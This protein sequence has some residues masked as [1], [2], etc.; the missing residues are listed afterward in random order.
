MSQGFSVLRLPQRWGPHCQAGRQNSSCQAA[1]H[2]LLSWTTPD[3]HAGS[4]EADAD[5]EP[6]CEDV[7]GSTL[8]KEGE[9]QDWAESRHRTAVQA[10]GSRDQPE[11]A[12]EGG[13]PVRVVPHGS[14]WQGF[15]P[16][17]TQSLDLDPGC[18][19]KGV[20]SGSLK[21]RLTQTELAAGSFGD[22]TPHIR[23]AGSALKGDEAVPLCVTMAQFTI[24][25]FNK[26]WLLGTV[27][28]SADTGGVETS[29]SLSLSLSLS[30][31][32][33]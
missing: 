18:P 25:S 2:H 11:G 22:L 14:R 3:W 8:L 23:A 13:P 7:R 32:E 20:T 21:P 4:L 31:V 5:T 27:L 9:K 6:E 33:I 19:R 26:H 12:P 24:H 28:G 30:L 15:I 1:P 10:C 17:L 16:Q 29:R